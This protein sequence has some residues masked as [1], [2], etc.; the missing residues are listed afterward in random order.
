V[1]DLRFEWDPKKAQAN[2]KEHG[3]SF[4]EAVAVF[5]D[6]H[7]LLED[8]PDQPLD[9]ERFLLL[10]LSLMP[11]LLV[12]VHCVRSGGDVIRIISSRKANKTEPVLL[13]AETMR[14]H[15]DFSKGR[16]NPYAA[17]LKRQI[18]IRLDRATIHYFQG[19][20]EST[21]IPYQTLINLYLRECA[22]SKRRPLLEW[23]AEKTDLT[24]GR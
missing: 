19:M 15:Y 9:E 4:E 24:G 12:V 11:R 16:R 1:L 2:L 14:R 10:G 22:S 7:A 6:E 18:T 5:Y 3:V 17:R 13:E 23:K 21:G 8:D 20:A